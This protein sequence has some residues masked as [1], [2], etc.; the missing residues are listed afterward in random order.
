MARLGAEA[1]L[2]SAGD[3]LSRPRCIVDHRRLGEP[4]DPLGLPDG[5]T[6][7]ELLRVEEVPLAHV[8]V[9]PD[10]RERLCHLL[11]GERTVFLH[12]VE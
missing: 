8:D 11:D 10:V 7:G 6:V 5:G 2:G 12:Y 4:G 9:E 1:L 3:P